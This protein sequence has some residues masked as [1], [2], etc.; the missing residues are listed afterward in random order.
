MKRPSFQFYPADWNTNSNLLRCSWAAQGAW[1]RVLCLLHDSDEYGL[2]RWTLKEMAQAIGAPVKLLT[3]L[4]QKGVLKGADKGTIEPYIYVPRSGRKSGDPVTLVPT[5]AGPLWYSSRMV[6]DEYV[7]QARGYGAGLG[8]GNHDAPKPSPKGGLG[9]RNGDDIGPRTPAQS[10]SSSPTVTESACA[11]SVTSARPQQRQQPP[12]QKIP[13][14]KD[15]Q[16]S[17]ADMAFVEQNTLAAPWSGEKLRRTVDEFRDHYLRTGHCSA[18]WS[19][20]WRLWVR[21][22]PRFEQHDTGPDEHGFRDPILRACA[23]DMGA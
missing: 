4:A 14:P 15:W 5:Q 7:R 2:L 10:S 23:A 17:A 1:V 16:P 8:D 20:D 19:A 9:A 11:A 6:R 12:P 3:E 13:I 18:D 22:Q 21:R